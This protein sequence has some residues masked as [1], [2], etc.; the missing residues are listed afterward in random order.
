[1]PLLLDQER[2]RPPV[3]SSLLPDRLFDK[4]EVRDN[5]LIIR[6]L[7]RRYHGQRRASKYN[8]PIV[9]DRQLPRLDDS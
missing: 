4:W 6:L 3:R 5:C 1:M 7:S 2:V 9:L 8:V